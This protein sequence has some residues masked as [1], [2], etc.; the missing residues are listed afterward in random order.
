MG[1]N[2]FSNVVIVNYREVREYLSMT[3]C[4][5]VLE[6]ALKALNQKNAL[7]PL[8]SSLWLPDKRGLLAIMPGYLGSSEVM[9]IKTVSVF[10]GN[11][12]TEFNSH[13]GSVIIYET[14][15]GCPLA[16]IDGGE[17]TAIRT[18]AASAVATKLLADKNA[19][20][21]AILGSGVQARNHLK[22]MITVRNIKRVRVWSKPEEHAQ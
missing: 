8:R 2:R 5:R 9:G 6:D 17:I 20:D 14:K 10:P 11:E 19:S 18:A 21:L 3:E 13:Q 4:I 1:K 12:G 22:A 16:V 15:N 7:N